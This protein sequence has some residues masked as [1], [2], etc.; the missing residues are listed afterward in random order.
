VRFT[1][2]LSSLFV[3]KQSSIIRSLDARMKIF[4]LA[5]VIVLSFA[6]QS[7]ACLF[8]LFCW[9]FVYSLIAKVIKPY[10]FVIKY[11]FFFALVSLLLMLTVVRDAQYLMAMVIH[12]GSKLFI[13]SSAGI[14]FA[15]TTSPHDLVRALQ[16]LRIPA[17]LTFPLTVAIRFIPK[18]LKEVQ[19]IQ[20]ALKLRGIEFRPGTVL[21]QPAWFYRGMFIP[22]IVRSI[23]ISDELSAAAESRGFGNPCKRTSFRHDI[24]HGHDYVFFFTVILVT[25]AL[26]FIDYLLRIGL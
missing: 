14:L 24:L 8:L 2:R 25:I 20:D 11:M 3:A 23:S 9:T 13:M 17:M 15:L 4:W 1:R 12:M 7:M 18:L 16:R 22:A 26:L 21:R 5:I 6:I 10:L 19:E